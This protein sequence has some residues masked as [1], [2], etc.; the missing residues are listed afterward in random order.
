MAR[1]RHTARNSMIP[2]LP[3]RLEERPLRRTVSGQSS[4]LER[5]DHRLR[6]EQERRL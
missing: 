3:S 2:F 1:L 6:G 5:L 4:Y